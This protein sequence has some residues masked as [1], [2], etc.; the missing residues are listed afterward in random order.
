M[1]GC[2]LSPGDL[3]AQQG[4]AA[5]LRP[6]VERVDAQPRLLEVVF[7]PA[8]DEA[9]VSELIETERGCCPFFTIDYDAGERRLQIA[10]AARSDEPA[11]AHLARFFTA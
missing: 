7:A 9:L 1:L 6:S 10:V 3:A 11:L 2:S 5:A 8:V 4:R